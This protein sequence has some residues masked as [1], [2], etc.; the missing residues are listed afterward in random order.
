MYLGAL[1]NESQAVVTVAPPAPVT[2]PSWGSRGAPH[3]YRH[4]TGDFGERNEFVRDENTGE[5]SEVP[6][7]LPAHV[8]AKIRALG[9]HVGA[10]FKAGVWPIMFVKSGK[11]VAAGTPGAT[12]IT[13]PQAPERLKNE[14][15]MAANPENHDNPP[16]YVR[17]VLAHRFGVH[18][19]NDA[20]APMM[21][22]QAVAANALRRARIIYYSPEWG[23]VAPYTAYAA[24]VKQHHP[25]SGFVEKVL[26]AAPLLMASAFAVAAWSG[27]FSQFTIADTAAGGTEVASGGFITD[28]EL[29]EAAEL[30]EVASAPIDTFSEPLPTGGEIA[31][32]DPAGYEFG[33]PDAS[34]TMTPDVPTEVVPVEGEVIP[35][36]TVPSFPGSP[37]LPPVASSGTLEKLVKAGAAWLLKPDP[38]APTRPA[39]I[40]PPNPRGAGALTDGL[41]IA[42]IGAILAGSLI[43]FPLKGKRHANGKS[44]RRR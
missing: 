43:A 8:V 15:I 40:L 18:P 36:E 42:A 12:L 39:T 37:S 29:A 13:F 19:K 1:G 27:T 10:N 30:S 4:P 35:A 26:A 32:A 5:I 20:I 34:G 23:W 22:T 21:E 2:G 14:F 33:T 31:T 9:F 28:A 6:R 7:L 24:I 41:L 17:G 3:P 11:P 16:V 38:K 25:D 44:R